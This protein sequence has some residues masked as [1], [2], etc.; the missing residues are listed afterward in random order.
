MCNEGGIDMAD[1]VLVVS[2]DSVTRIG[3]SALFRRD[4]HAGRVYEARSLQDAVAITIEDQP[5]LAVLDADPALMEGMSAFTQGA[6]RLPIVVVAR[7]DSA[8]LLQRALKAGAHGFVVCA[9][10]YVDA[11][12]RVIAHARRGERAVCP[13]SLQH[14]IDAYIERPCEAPPTVTPRETDVLALI[15]EG[16]TNETIARQLHLSAGT[17]K[18]H[19]TSILRKLGAPTRAAAAA[20]T[21][22]GHVLDDARSHSRD[23]GAR[24]T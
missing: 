3:L 18:G 19:V 20:R 10:D 23:N 17:V 12:F 9:G 16:H 22:R 11:L 7:H 15:V 6:S 1:G 4:R 2:A 21:V 5:A 8:A 13:V 24:S 14:L